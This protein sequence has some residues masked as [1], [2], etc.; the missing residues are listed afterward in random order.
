MGKENQKQPGQIKAV[1]KP[2]HNPV[3]GAGHWAGKWM[4]NQ[5]TSD[6]RK[7]VS[8]IGSHRSQGGPSAADTT[9]KSSR[10][11]VRSCRGE[12]WSCRGGEAKGL[13]LS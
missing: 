3:P 11:G 5:G 7:W 2:P 10:D 9:V 6:G 1:S 12:V 8:E 13:P 4:G